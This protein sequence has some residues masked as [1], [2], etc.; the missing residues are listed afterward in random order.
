MQCPQCGAETPDQDWNCVNCRINVYWATQH[1]DELARIRSQQGLK[2][3]APTP[4][5]LVKT[6]RSVVDER[7]EAGRVENKV[8]QIARA[9]MRPKA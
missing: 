1:Y 7:G 6:Q 2:E 4:A 9:A 8:R 3:A 5:F